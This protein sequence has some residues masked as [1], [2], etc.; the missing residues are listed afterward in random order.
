MAWRNSRSPSFAP[1]GGEIW[2]AGGALAVSALACGELILA[3]DALG[4]LRGAREALV[5]VDLALWIAAIAWLPL[6]VA[7]E[8]RRPRLRYHPARWAT[9]FPVG[10]YAA[11]SF[12]TGRALGLGAITDFARLW[13]WIALAV[14]CLAAL[15]LARRAAAR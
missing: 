3:D 14:W 10:M 12:V 13:T 7:A 1:G 6:L 11:C 15:G 5:S 4:V 8:L 2:I 9:V